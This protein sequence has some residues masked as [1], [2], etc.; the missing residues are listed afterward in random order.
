MIDALLYAVRDAVRAAGF[1]YGKAECEITGEG[2][3]PPP[4]CGNWFISV[5]DGVSRPGYA[6]DNNLY[7]FY[8]YSVTVTARIGKTSFD[9]VGDQLISRNLVRVPQGYKEGFNAK[10][11][12]LRAF[13][14]MNWPI[15][16]LQNQTPNSANDNLAAWSTGT[17]YGFTEPARYNGAGRVSDAPPGWFG[18]DAGGGDVPFGLKAEMRFEGAKRFQPY[19]PPLPVAVL[20]A[21]LSNPAVTDITTPLSANVVIGQRYTFTANLVFTQAHASAYDFTIVGLF[22]TATITP[23]SNANVTSIQGGTLLAN[24]Q[25][26]NSVFYVTPSSTTGTFTVQGEFTALTTGTIALSFSLVMGDS[27]PIILKAGSSLTV[28]QEGGFV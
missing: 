12:Q 24:P 6:N 16:V 27:A 5:H 13:L 11:E 20:A 7:E 19:T 4:K 10:V 15:T 8:D 28:L 18:E 17:V 21:D 9:R 23:G 25:T 1:N 22:S 3:K 26:A 14:H 2:G